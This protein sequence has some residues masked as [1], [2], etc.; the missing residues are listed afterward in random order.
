MTSIGTGET[1]RTSAV[2]VYVVLILAL[3][4][5]LLVVSLEAFQADDEALAWPAAALSVGLFA[6]TLAF[7]RLLRRD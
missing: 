4:V 2:F 7:A 6:T 3:Q 1:K 5:F